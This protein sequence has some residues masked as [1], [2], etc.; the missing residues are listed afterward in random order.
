[1]CS[2]A[3]NHFDPTGNIELEAT[4]SDE[5]GPPIEAYKHAYKQLHPTTATSMV[6]SNQCYS[7]PV[8]DPVSLITST[9]LEN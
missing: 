5:H 2:R 7:Y 6:S 3:K 8:S 4:G 1:M 9:F